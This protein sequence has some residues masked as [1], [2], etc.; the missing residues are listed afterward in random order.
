MPDNSAR[1]CNDLAISPTQYLK[2]TKPKDAV[3]YS[4]TEARYIGVISISFH[5][6]KEQ[7]PLYKVENV[8]EDM[9]IYTTTHTIPA[10]D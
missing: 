10:G 7:R 8:L 2:P 3:G 1:V 9:N 6:A 5:A 4:L